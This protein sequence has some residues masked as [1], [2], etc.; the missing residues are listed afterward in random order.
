MARPV[1]KKSPFGDYLIEDETWVNELIEEQRELN[2]FTE[3]R[4]TAIREVLVNFKEIMRKKE[5]YKFNIIKE[6]KKII[7]SCEPRAHLSAN[8]SVRLLL[9]ENDQ[10]LDEEFEKLSMAVTEQEIKLR[11]VIRE[12]RKFKE[13]RRK[14]ILKR[15]K[16]FNLTEAPGLSKEFDY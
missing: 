9:E 2:A 16:E 5:T 12:L 8:Y 1:Y 3:E 10:N 7:F 6:I 14:R 4:I 13:Q 11:R 15:K